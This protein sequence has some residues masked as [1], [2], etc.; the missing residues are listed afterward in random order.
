MSTQKN[1]VTY[2]TNWMGPINSEWIKENGEGWS[3][4][5]IDI[6]GVID[7]DGIYDEMRL[8]PMKSGSWRSFSDWLDTVTTETVHELGTLV[9]WYYMEGNLEIWWFHDEDNTRFNLP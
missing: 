1:K 6:R 4:G 5:R 7:G 3:A 8:P 2:S 9:D